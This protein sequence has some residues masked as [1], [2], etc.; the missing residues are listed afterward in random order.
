MKNIA[1][2]FGIHGK[3]EKRKVRKTTEI[4]ILIFINAGLTYPYKLYQ[5]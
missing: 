4:E 5:F 3:I 2:F 1:L